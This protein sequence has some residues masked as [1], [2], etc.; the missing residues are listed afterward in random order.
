[1]KMNSK[2]ILRIFTV[3]KEKIQRKQRNPK[4][5][6]FKRTN[7]TENFQQVDNKK[8]IL[9][10]MKAFRHCSWLDEI[11]FTDIAGDVR[12]EIFHQMFPLGSHSWLARTGSSSSGKK[13]Y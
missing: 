9:T 1:M 7:V 11:P 5:G 8:R 2:L 6:G 10:G 13:G 3:L 12:I 4:C